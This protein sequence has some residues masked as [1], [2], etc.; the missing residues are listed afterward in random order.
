MIVLITQ[1]HRIL[2]PSHIT[3]GTVASL[4]TLPANA[5]GISTDD[6]FQIYEPIKKV[7]GQSS[8]QICCV[9]YSNDIML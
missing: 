1:F 7:E 3:E 2:S 6:A 4:Y 8:K 5:R 9:K